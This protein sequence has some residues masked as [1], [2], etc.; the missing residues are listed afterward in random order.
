MYDEHTYKHTTMGFIED[1]EAMPDQIEYSK[2]FFD[3]WYRPE[4]TVVILVGDL[5]ADETFDLVEKYWGDWE[6]GDYNIEIPVEP[7][8]DGP[9]Y[10]HYQWESP[11]QSW[12]TMAYRGPAYRPTEKD[13]PALDL[14]SSIYFSESSDLYQK[15]VIQEQ[16]VDQLFGY[17]PDQLDPGMLI[18]A[19]RL[20]EANNAAAV[21]D[22]INATLVEARTQLASEEKVEETKSRLRYEFTAQLDNSG[23]HRPRSRVFRAV[24]PHARND[25]R[26]LRDL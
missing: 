1:I 8:L 17:F 11:T 20:T 3:R 26:G 2:V 18:I 6:R 19:A 25:Q 5:D 9:V 10:E 24:F 15:V 7:P 16:S 4:K 22:A 13:M 21:R 12:L 14:M 23:G